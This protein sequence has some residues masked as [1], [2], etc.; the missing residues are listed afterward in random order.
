M[1]EESLPA[2][3]SRVSTC[4]ELTQLQR[5]IISALGPCQRRRGLGMQHGHTRSTISLGQAA[6]RRIRNG[7]TSDLFVQVAL[8]QFGKA[9]ALPGKQEEPPQLLVGRMLPEGRAA[10][11]T[12]RPRILSRSQSRWFRV[13]CRP[14]VL[15]APGCGMPGTGHW[16][17]KRAPL[18]S[19]L[20]VRDA[21]GYEGEHF[22]HRRCTCPNKHGLTK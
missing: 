6:L 8:H 1:V 22:C 20:V 13:H 5:V 18:A 17:R 7:R 4:Q 10:S 16:W 12:A 15:R 14:G 21:G 19:G 9:A 3:S 11:G 2:H